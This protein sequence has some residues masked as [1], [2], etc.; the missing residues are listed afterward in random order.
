MAKYVISLPG[1][2]QSILYVKDGL[3]NEIIDYHVLEAVKKAVPL[4]E[5]ISKKKEVKRGH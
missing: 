3:R 5:F 1:E 4:E 2:L